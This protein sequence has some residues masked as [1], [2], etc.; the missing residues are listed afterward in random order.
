MILY[1][2]RH[3]QSVFNAEG[4][5][6]GQHDVHLSE[7][8]HRQAKATADRL[9]ALSRSAPPAGSPPVVY[10][11]PLSRALQT[12]EYVA[13]A[14]DVPLRIEENLKEI[15]AGIFQTMLWSEIED[16]FPH[17]GLLWKQQDPDFVVPGG[18]SRRALMGRGAQA[19]QT[20]REDCSGNGHQ[21]AVVVAHGALLS[22]AFKA[23]LGIPAERSPFVFANCSISQAEWADQFRLLRFNELTHLEGLNAPS[24]SLQG[25]S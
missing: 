1:F 8:G 9:A 6:Q 4:R 12:A 23:L 25:N 16:K 15:H 10:C 22:A 11:S 19:L 17:E 20:I 5:I 24:L 14:L 18:E 13:Q 7:L 3:G 2:V 21:A